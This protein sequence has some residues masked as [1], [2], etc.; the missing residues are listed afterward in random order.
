MPTG[1]GKSL[2]HQLPALVEQ[3][4]I[5]ISPLI[6]QDQVEQVNA[7]STDQNEIAVYPNS[8][9]DEDDDRP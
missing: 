4:R 8:T 7:L 9:Q 3:G 1:G 6:V 2:C 5:V